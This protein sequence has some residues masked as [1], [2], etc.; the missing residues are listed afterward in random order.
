MRRSTHF[1]IDLHPISRQWWA[2]FL[3]PRADEE[4]RKFVT[5]RIHK[6]SKG[7]PN[8]HTYYFFPSGGVAGR[9]KIAHGP[10]AARGP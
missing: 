8:V 1:E 7:T 6:S 9:T 3:P 10:H 2:T 4:L 5:G